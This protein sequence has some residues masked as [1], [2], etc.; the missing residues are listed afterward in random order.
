MSPNHVPPTPLDAVDPYARQSQTNAALD[1]GQVERLTALGTLERVPAGAALF[2][3]GQRN[4]DFLLVVSGSIEIFDVDVCGDERVFMIHGP[5]QFTGELDLFNERPTLVSAR[6]ASESEL[7]RIRRADFRRV[8]AA[9]PDIGELIMRALIL[10]RVGLIRHAQGGVVLLGS[11][12]AGDTLRLQRFLLQNGYPHR[13][14]DVDSDA[15]A[16]RF[17]GC[18]ALAPE[19]LPAIVDAGDRVLSKPSISALADA[20]GISEPILPDHVHDVTVIGAGPGGLAAAVYAAS[21]GLDTL[22]IE[23]TAPGGQAGTSSKIENYLGFPTG[24]SGQA[25]AGRAQVQAQKFGARLAISRAAVGIDCSQHPYR[26]LLEG[27]GSILTRAVVVATGAHYRTLDIPNYERFAGQGIHF[28]ATAMERELCAGQEVV[29]VGAANSAG[30]AAIYLSHRLP[31]VH[32]LCRGPGLSATMSRYLIERIEASPRITVHAHTQLSGLEGDGV[33]REVTWTNARTGASETRP[34]ENVFSMI[35]A[36]P[37][38]RWLD[39]CLELDAKG[40]VLTGPEAGRV[41]S[42][43]ETS[44]PGVYA[45]GDVRA[46]SIKRVASAVGEGSAV[47]QAI[48]RFLQPQA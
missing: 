29:V 32:M 41:A 44:R 1:E 3:R 31:H 5:G 20:L 19:E 33:L 23:G 10:R 14:L 4:V 18:V 2:T 47:V 6:T 28:A 38:T 39:G 15:D 35:G 26:V 17:M 45:V 34:I 12:H 16:R 37:R 40:F 27:G 24:I 11:A 7:V 48:H 8:L 22:V 46:G 30:Q 43:F 25:L 13:V 42:P 36:E 9:E 21:E